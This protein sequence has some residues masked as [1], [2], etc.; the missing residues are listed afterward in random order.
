[1]E[2]KIT[3]PVTVIELRSSAVV[4]T[5]KVTVK[6]VPDGDSKYAPRELVALYNVAKVDTEIVLEITNSTT[7]NPVTIVA[8]INATGNVTFYVDGNIV[9]NVTVVNGIAI[10][11]VVKPAGG[12]HVVNVTYNG[13]SA[14]SPKDKNGTKFMVYPNN[15][16]DMTIIGD[17]KPYGENSTFT[18][19]NIPA[20][21]LGNNLTVKI[22]NVSYLILS[23]Y[24]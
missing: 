3:E 8:N 21:I 14:Y 18:F 2:V 15:T 7:A 17:Y 19:R 20:D 10:L 13:D 4:G 12:E 9:E 16:W 24:M 5:N 1:M 22:D 6:Y 11:N 23:F